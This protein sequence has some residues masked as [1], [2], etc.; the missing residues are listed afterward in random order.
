MKKGVETKL[1]ILSVIIILLLILLFYSYQKVTGNFV[2][3]QLVNFEGANSI[4]PSAEEQECM[5]S[6]MGCTSIGVN[7]TGNQEQCF[8]QCGVDK[9]EVTQET[10]CMESCVVKGCSEFD[11]GCQAKNQDS[12]EKECN[13][14]KEPE[15]KSEEEQCIRTCVNAH[16][17]GTICRPSQEGEQGNDVCKM[18]AQQCVHLY[19]GPCLGEEKLEAKKIECATC[20]HCYAKIIMGDSGEGWE[21]IV[22]VECADASS[23]FGDE[24]GAGP[25]V[26][27]EGFNANNENG[28]GEGFESGQGGFVAS[29]SATIGNIV[30]AIGDFFSNLFGSK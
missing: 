12:C 17:P 2:L 1:I 27:Q 3:G 10:S 20:E 8:I 15:A 29:V 28:S 4:G 21:C 6:C 23:E 30:E 14:I 5:R 26:G 13:M 11:F 16:S 7:C 22:G 25:G 9:P 19:A 18:C 24:P